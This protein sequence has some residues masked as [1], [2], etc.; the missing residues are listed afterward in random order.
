MDRTTKIL[1]ATIAIGLWANLGFS[2]F[3]PVAA[4]AQS[5]ELSGIASNLSS[6]AGGV[7]VN[8]KIC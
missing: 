1:L 4:V 2:V 7:C 8:R 3:R 5:Y 6:I